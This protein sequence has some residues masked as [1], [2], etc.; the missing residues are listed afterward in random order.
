MMNY[1]HE[2]VIHQREFVSRTGIHTT[3]IESFWGNMK[4]KLKAKRGSQ[5]AML[6]GFID[7]YLYRYNRK[8]EGNMF[9]LMLDDIARYYPV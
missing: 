4:I 9:N 3:W 1:N 5:G 8:N 7:E 2:T 6:D